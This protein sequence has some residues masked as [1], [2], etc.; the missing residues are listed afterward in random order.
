M[1]RQ[2]N[3]K[4]GYI[5]LV[6]TIILGLVLLTLLLVASNTGLLA[7][8]NILDAESKE[9]SMQTAVSCIGS[10][11]LKVEQDTQYAGGEILT[12]GDYLCWIRPRSSGEE[13][14]VQVVVNNAYT[15]FEVEEDGSD[16]R[17]CTHFSI[18]GACVLP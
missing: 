9:I 12:V 5:A 2:N 8:F 17:E 10:A 18:S 11:L 1:N 15:N 7:R 4:G 13:M 14:Q 3:K 6:T 16:F